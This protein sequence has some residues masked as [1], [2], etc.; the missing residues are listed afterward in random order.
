MPA[1]RNSE[2]KFYTFPGDAQGLASSGGPLTRKFVTRCQV[3]IQGQGYSTNTRTTVWDT[4]CSVNEL[5]QG[6][7]LITSLESWEIAWIF[8]VDVRIGHL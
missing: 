5:L 1:V 8:C 3:V 6:L 7:A 2:A 4:A